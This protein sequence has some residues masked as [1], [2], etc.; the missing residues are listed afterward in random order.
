MSTPV[1]WYAVKAQWY[2]TGGDEDGYAT[3]STCQVYFD[4]WI[5][6]RE[7]THTVVLKRDLLGA[8]WTKRVYKNA[9]RRWAHPT[10]EEA[11][12]DF[13]RR[14]H[15]VKVFA[16][17]R[18]RNAANELVRLDYELHRMQRDDLIPKADARPALSTVLAL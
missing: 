2:A 13:R 1:K 15:W 8:W 7:T 18:I 5:V 6:E 11:V 10:L 14:K 3:G 16:E 17:R 9:R 4:E 12:A